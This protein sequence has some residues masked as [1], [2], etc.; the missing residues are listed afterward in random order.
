MKIG[1]RF[2]VNR[3]TD[4]SGVSG[5]GLVAEGTQFHDGQ[6]AVSWYG[7]HHILEVVKDLDTWLAVHGHGGRTKIVWVDKT[8]KCPTSISSSKRLGSGS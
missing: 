3:V 6:C 1:K 8:S 2:L 5:V 4:V 7:E